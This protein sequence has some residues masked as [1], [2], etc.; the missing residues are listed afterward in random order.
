[1]TE[2]RH[3][4]AYRNTLLTDDEGRYVLGHLL[5][6][7]NYFGKCE[8]LADMELRNIAVELLEDLGILFIENAGLKFANRSIENFVGVISKLDVT[9]LVEDQRKEIE[10]KREEV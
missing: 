2:E 4:L 10:A 5:T 6:R 7:L 3:V 9:H 1:M 8:T